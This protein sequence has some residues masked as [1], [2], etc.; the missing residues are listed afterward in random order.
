MAT[1]EAL[2]FSPPIALGVVGLILLL[3]RR[4]ANF[5]I[6]PSLVV[7]GASIGFSVLFFCFEPFGL[8]LWLVD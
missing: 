2:R 7:L 6:R 1:V 4:D 8:T 3:R 5:R